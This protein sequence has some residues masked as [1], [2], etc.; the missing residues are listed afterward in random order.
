M[1][2][3]GKSWI[4]AR[5]RSG[6]FRNFEAH[7]FIRWKGD[8]QNFSKARMGEG[9][10]TVPRPLESAAVQTPKI[11]EPGYA[12]RIGRRCNE[13]SGFLLWRRL[14]WGGA[15][16][17]FGRE[18]RLV[19]DRSTGD[20]KAHPSRCTHSLRRVIALKAIGSPHIYITVRLLSRAFRVFRRRWLMKRGCS[21]A[22]RKRCLRLASHNEIRDHSM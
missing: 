21:A 2:G 7:N 18:N 14:K 6:L 22:T 9:R 3:E 20:D 4:K 16:S 1:E 11:F 13:T 19:S 8:L 15:R 12:G 10:P 17:V 5:T